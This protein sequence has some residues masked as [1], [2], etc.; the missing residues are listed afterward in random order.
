MSGGNDWGAPQR[1]HAQSCRDKRFALTTTFTPPAVC[2][3]YWT[4]VLDTNSPSNTLIYSFTQNMLKTEC[5]PTRDSLDCLSVSIYPT[6]SPGICPQGWSDAVSQ[7][8]GTAC[9]PTLVALPFSFSSWIKSLTLIRQSN[10]VPAGTSPYICESTFKSVQA[11]TFQ[12]DKT[13]SQTYSS[14]TTLSSS[15]ADSTS[16]S[17]WGSSTTYSASTVIVV[18]A[19]KMQVPPIW[20]IP[21]D[22]RQLQSSTASQTPLNTSERSPTATQTSSATGSGR[23]E[24]STGAIAGIIV[25]VVL[26]ALLIG[27]GALLFWKRKRR[28]ARTVPVDVPSE[29]AKPELDGL[30][31]THRELDSSPRVEL[32][33]IG[34]TAELE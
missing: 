26:I 6:F 11:V 2:S 28:A 31:F 15:G 16:T 33:G 8:P 19:Q 23:N 30:H 21:G 12:Y 34:R 10:F 13:Y 25:P 3:S 7:S 32:T 29:E 17:I 4:P 14:K 22:E 24:L 1:E 27:C 9:C 5:F 20:I 18:S